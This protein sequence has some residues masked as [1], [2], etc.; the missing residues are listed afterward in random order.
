MYI[1]TSNILKTNNDAAWWVRLTLITVEKNG[2]IKTGVK[3]NI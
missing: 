2:C 1:N 3:G